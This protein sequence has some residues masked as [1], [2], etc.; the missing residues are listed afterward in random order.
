MCKSQTAKGD[1]FCN[2]NLRQQLSVHE[3]VVLLQ[4]FNNCGLIGSAQSNLAGQAAKI[5]CKRIWESTIR[6]KTQHRNVNW[7]PRHL[8]ATLAPH[9]D[10]GSCTLETGVQP[11]AGPKMM[12]N[13]SIAGQKENLLS[14]GRRARKHMVI[15]LCVGWSQPKSRN[16]KEQ[17]DLPLN[18]CAKEPTDLPP[19]IIQ[20]LGR[21]AELTKW[22]LQEMATCVHDWKQ[23]RSNQKKEFQVPGTENQWWTACGQAA[24]QTV[25][26]PPQFFALAKATAPWSHS[27][28]HPGLSE[29]I[30]RIQERGTD[31]E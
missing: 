31:C 24:C 3:H 25:W 2:Q 26:V 16:A 6:A 19:N 4:P 21:N 7:K 22:L 28:G 23:N 5:M 18:S 12:R 13:G 8:R 15:T 20:Y 14:S 11:T 10:N 29:K 1:G 17:I 27:V 9:F 30:S